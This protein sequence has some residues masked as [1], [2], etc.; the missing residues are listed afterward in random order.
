MLTGTGGN[1]GGQS[2]VAVIR[3]LSL[4]EI[5]LHDALRVFWKEMRVATICGA[6]LAAAT[7]LKVMALD[8]KFQI[9]EVSAT[10][11]AQNNLHLA[12]IISVTV[13]CAV[14]VAKAVGAL[15]PIGAKRI[16][17]DP[18]VMASPFIT[19]VVDTLTLVIYFAIASAVLHF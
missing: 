16:G 6:V 3:A 7:F 13:F 9:T 14:L 19:T 10:G 11:V 12:L 17:I 2:S 5:E 4:G 18:A 8:F 1:A 15:L